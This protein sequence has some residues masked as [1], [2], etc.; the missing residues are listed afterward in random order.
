MM[1]GA[2]MA[3]RPVQSAEG[4]GPCGG[5]ATRPATSRLFRPT[6]LPPRVTDE[7]VALTPGL[8][9]RS[10]AMAAEVLPSAKW[11]YCGEP[12][13][14][15]RA[16]LGKDCGAGA[17][18]PMTPLSVSVPSGPLSQLGQDSSP[19]PPCPTPIPCPPSPALV[20]T[21]TWVSARAPLSSHHLSVSTLYLDEDIPVNALPK[22]FTQDFAML[23]F[24]RS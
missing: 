6:A 1:G 19:K 8:G 10:G 18:P 17:E 7:L 22:G 3:P 9:D 5:G 12:D 23:S 14:S 21:A 20:P 11:L 13:E 2:G 15:Q 24:T 16:V 4:A